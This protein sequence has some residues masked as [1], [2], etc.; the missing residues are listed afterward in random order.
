[1]IWNQT[2]LIPAMIYVYGEGVMNVSDEEWVK[3]RSRTDVKTAIK[4][5]VVEYLNN[6]RI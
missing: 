3:L 2:I 4:Y 6:L 5:R 1:M